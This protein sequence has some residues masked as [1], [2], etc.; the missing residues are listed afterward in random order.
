M[1]L[2]SGTQFKAIVEYA[3]SQRVPKPGTKKDGREGTIM[4]GAFFLK[5][6]SSLLGMV[7]NGKLLQLTLKCH[8]WLVILY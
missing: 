3:P 4:K 2:I 7:F 6:K 8:L 5:K 1:P